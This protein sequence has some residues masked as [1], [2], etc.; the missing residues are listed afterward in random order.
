MLF[1]CRSSYQK[2][3]HGKL[4]GEPS[5]EPGIYISTYHVTIM[6]KET[7]LGTI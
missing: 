4:D 2:L 6:C 3:Y 5:T 7:P 1:Y